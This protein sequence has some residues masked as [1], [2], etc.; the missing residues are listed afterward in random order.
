M[1]GSGS[2]K[3]GGTG[4]TVDSPCCG[5]P[6][7][8]TLYA[9]IS[10]G[11]GCLNGTWKLTWQAGDWQYLGIPCGG[12]PTNTVDISMSCNLA[13]GEWILGLDVCVIGEGRVAINEN[14]CD[15]IDI[16]FTVNITEA[17]C[18]DCCGC[19][20]TGSVTVVVTQ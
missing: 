6:V 2:P 19:G 14:L 8:Q 10:G 5:T 15:P 17:A 7:P 1:S 11:C 3:S 20:T 4:G 9:E 16:T 18:A 12:D 13:S